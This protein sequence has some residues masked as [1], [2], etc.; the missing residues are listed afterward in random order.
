LDIP[1]KTELA[2]DSLCATHGNRW[3]AIST[4]RQEAEKQREILTALLGNAGGEVRPDMNFVIF[5]SLS[6]GEWTSGSDIDWSLLHLSTT[7]KTG[8]ALKT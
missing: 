7:Q 6:R 1:V 8:N 3:N 2:F 4:A 5:G